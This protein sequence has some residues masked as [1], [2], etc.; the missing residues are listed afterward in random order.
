MV[1]TMVSRR[2]IVR[3]HRRERQFLV[4]GTL[5]I[6]IAAIAFVAAA[7]YQ[8][9]ASLPFTQ[10]F[11]TPSSQA[12]IEINVPCPPTDDEGKYPM[13][14]G[15]ISVRVLN[16]T[17]KQGLAGST[18]ELLT[19]RG[20]VS[21]GAGNWGRTY[22]GTVRIQ[23]GELG[24]RQAYTIALTFPD[25][26]LVLDNRNSAVVDVILGSSFEIGDDTRVAYAPELDPSLELTASG[27]C[28]PINLVPQAP[29]PAIIPVD[30][31][32]SLAA[33]EPSASA[34]P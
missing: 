4:F 32:A 14:N 16:G 26:E 29:A 18:M 8:G 11:V 6:A 13:P 1:R 10:A 2:E 22:D 25:H 21:A 23:F 31:L 28:L 15:Q 7:V 19:G 27:A 24:L 3:R 20:M 12:E 5:F 33:T 34:T 9:R 17:D 30:P